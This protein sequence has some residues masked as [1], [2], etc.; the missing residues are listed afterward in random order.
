MAF[1]AR[2][3]KKNSLP[4]LTLPVQFVTVSKVEGG[5]ESDAE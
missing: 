5:D 3:E 1:Q 4:V 2:S